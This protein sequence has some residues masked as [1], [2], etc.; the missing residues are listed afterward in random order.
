MTRPELRSEDSDR[1]DPTAA[2]CSHLRSALESIDD[3]AAS[4]HLRQALQLLDV[5]ERPADR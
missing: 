4:Y 1:P 3:P 2:I 5:C